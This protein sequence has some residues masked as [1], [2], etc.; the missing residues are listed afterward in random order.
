VNE[1]KK[2]DQKLDFAL[3][4]W[5]RIQKCLRE[6]DVIIISSER[7][8]N[9]EREVDCCAAVD[10][11]KTVMMKMNECRFNFHPSDENVCVLADQL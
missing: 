11:N 2:F 8:S 7:N 1:E 10:N 9:F 3:A 6:F 5:L 4:R